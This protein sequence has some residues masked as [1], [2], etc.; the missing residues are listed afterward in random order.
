MGFFFPKA[1][2]RKAPTSPAPES[3]LNPR[4]QARH[5][6]HQTSNSPVW[7][8]M[9]GLRGVWRGLMPGGVPFSASPPGRIP[10]PSTL[11]SG[12]G[13]ESEGRRRRTCTLGGY[14]FKINTPN[15]F[16]VLFLRSDDRHFSP[17]PLVKLPPRYPTPDADEHRAAA[18]FCPS[19]L[20]TSALV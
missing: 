5:T 14:L 9:D 13:P 10:A 4:K 20:C 19:T 17:L 8:A 11:Q 2:S 1:G 6:D 7:A 16:V 15:T 3:P 18:L 12:A